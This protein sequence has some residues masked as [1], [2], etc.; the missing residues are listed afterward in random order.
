MFLVLPTH[1]FEPFFDFQWYCCFPSKEVNFDFRRV[2]TEAAEPQPER[3]E[4]ETTI[5]KRSKIALKQYYKNFT[6]PVG[7]KDRVTHDVNGR[8]IIVRE[9]NFEEKGMMDEEAYFQEMMAAY[10][11]RSLQQTRAENYDD[12]DWWPYEWFLKVGTEYYFRYEGTQT[13]PPCYDTSHYRVFKDPIRVA[14]HQMRELERLI[15]W[16]RNDNCEVDTAGKSTESPNRVDVARPIQSYHKWHRKVF[17]ECQDWPSKFPADREWC[18]NWQNRPPEERLFYKPY[19]WP[20]DGF[21]F[22]EDQIPQ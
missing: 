20:S 19:N 3:K 14:P 10:K 11:R 17:C 15:A 6:H 22:L 8:E 12:V 7:E 9:E 18:R 13:V 21:D 2:L 5:L 1:F 4:R 16:R